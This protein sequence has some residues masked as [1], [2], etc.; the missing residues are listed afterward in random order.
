MRAHAPTRFWVA[1]NWM[2]VLCVCAGRAVGDPQ[3]MPVTAPVTAKVELVATNDQQA[4]SRAPAAKTTDASNV[5][6][7]LAPLDENGTLRSAGTA[8]PGP[9]P[10]LVQRNKTF[11]PH[12]L[13]I[14]AGTSIQFPN[15]DPFFHNVFSLL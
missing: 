12:V 7:W 10:Q 1:F 13:I 4:A 2:L 11:Q 5:A 9:A 15:K 14:E 3:Q 8:P 6:V